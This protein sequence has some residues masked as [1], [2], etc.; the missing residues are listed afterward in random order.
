MFRILFALYLAFS[1]F[2]L[3][4]EEGSNDATVINGGIQERDHDKCCGGVPPPPCPPTC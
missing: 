3:T 4:V 1:P 2:L